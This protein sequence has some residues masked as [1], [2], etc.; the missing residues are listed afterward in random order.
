MKITLARL[1]LFIAALSTVLAQ[2][3]TPPSNISPITGPGLVG[4]ESGTGRATTIAVG[5][6]L[7][8]VG[9]VIVAT[10][11]GGGGAPSNATYI[12]QIPNGTL[13]NEQALSLL[14]TGIMYVT[15]STGQISSLGP[16]LSGTFGGTGNGFMNFS[17]PA[18]S[19]K[20]FTLPNASATI[21]TTNA[22][23][24]V[25]QGGTG[26]TTF[27]NG[28]LLIGNTTNGGLDKATLTAG[29][30]VTITNAA[31]SI[32]I[33]ATGTGGNVTN[34][35]TL[36]S[37][38]VVLGGGTTVVGV[39]GA[40]T[41]G[42]VLIGN[43]T[44]GN[45]QLGSITAGSN[46]TVTPA[47]GGI[48]ISS[49]GSGNTSAVSTLVS[50]NL[51]QGA[52]TTNVTTTNIGV[53]GNDLTVPGNLTING[54][55]ISSTGTLNGQLW[56]GSTATG[57][58]TRATLTAGD[59]ISITNGAGSITINGTGSGNVTGSSLTSNA[60]VVGDGSNAIKIGPAPGSSGN[61][62]TSNGTAWTS[63]SPTFYQNIVVSGCTTVTG[64]STGNLTLV[65][66]G[67]ITLTTD[68]TAK[69]V[70]I[71]AS[72]GGGGNVTINA[73]LSVDDTYSGVTLVGQ[74]AGATIAQWEIVY[75]DSSS[76]W[77][78]ADA[79]GTNT[80]PAR[81]MAVAAY[82]STN[83]ATILREGAVRND[84]WNWTPGG[85]IYMSGTPGAITQTAP[86]ASGDK[87][88]QVG[89]ALTADIAY[90]NFASGEFL[91][92]P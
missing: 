5:N 39:L 23:V 62:A 84:A 47:A 81:G 75:L 7:E 35:A 20:T 17:G 44:S 60:M 55:N 48:T 11:G 1:L 12:T 68:N 89:Y 69:S 8:I 27:L 22:P 61:I 63:A 82:S 29:D 33:N 43:T 78:L 45:L 74:N 64:N 85:T 40:A 88:Q 71:A 3:T 51:V 37:G 31:G 46:I 72:G 21:L 56:I 41:N 25:A 70:T 87:I 26:Q 19:L 86:S 4:R 32:T 79:N 67:N 18:T 50:G 34:N 77:Q 83:P 92:V 58:L 59:N 38:R 49:S 91:T 28:Q 73:T 10:G 15:T 53:L 13:T 80:Y 65:A 42:Q 36:T 24:T 54:G 52:G 66:G 9:N 14:T 57:N 76:T 90:F 30:G 16:I 2:P 6:G